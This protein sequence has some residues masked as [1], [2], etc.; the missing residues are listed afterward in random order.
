[1]HKR[2]FIPGPTEVLE[3]NLQAMAKPMIGHRAK[4]FSVLYDEIIPK[5]KKFFNTENFVMLS[6]SSATGLM[7]GSVRNLVKKKCLNL[8][9]GAFSDRWHEI[10]LANGIKADKVQVDWGKAIKP[11]MVDEKLKTGEYDAVTLVHNETST[12][13]TNPIKEI[14]EVIRKY[15]DVMFIVDTV[16]SAGGIPICPDKLG[17]DFQ[18]FG[19][20]KCFALP[21]G[22]AIG[23]ISDKAVERAKTVENR[24]YYFDILA[25]MKSAEKSQT[26][27]TP[28]I[29]HMYALNNQLDRMLSQGDKIFERHKEMAK[30]TREWAKRHFEMFSE[31]GY[32]SDTVSCIK[33]T[34]GVSISDLNK[35]LARK[36]KMLSNGY[37]KIKD[38]TFRIGH[39]G[40]WQVSDIKELLNDVDEILGL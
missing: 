13:V 9:C 20:Q 12:G 31:K 38:E 6:T 19:L 26:P 32:E 39:M 14:G 3:E 30:I 1:M 40:D 8:C 24:G 18:L 22:F 23:I 10:T 25:Y 16:S 28:S 17:I 11:E 2:L 34:K 15:D 4:E 36:G 35:E 7:E 21:P 33:N 5:V 37:G 27:I 29:S